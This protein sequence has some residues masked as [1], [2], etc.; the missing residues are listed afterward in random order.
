[1]PYSGPNDPNLPD[2]VKK[3][4]ADLQRS[5]IRTYE[6]AKQFAT[7]K[8]LANV[9]GYAM[10]T[11]NT[12]L[13]KAKAE[14]SERNAERMLEADAVPETIEI[15]VFRAGDYGEKGVYSKADVRAMAEDYCADY[16]EAPVTLDHVDKGQAFGWVKS[17]R[18]QGETLFATLHEFAPEF[19]DLLQA[20]KFR[21]RSAEIYRNFQ[22]TGRPHLRAVTFLG[23]GIPAVKG[24]RDFSFEEADAQHGDH[25]VIEYEI[26]DLGEIELTK[27]AEMKTEDGRQFPAKAYAYVPD[28]QKPSTWKL[29]L[30]ETPEKKV[31]AAQLGRAAAAFSPGG[32]RGQKVQIPAGDIARIKARIRAAYR[33]LGV[34][35]KAIPA[36]IRASETGRFQHCEFAMLEEAEFENTK[37]ELTF[38]FLKPGFNSAPKGSRFSRYYSEE[39]I[40]ANHE[41]FRGKMFADHK[42]DETSSPSVR[43]IRSW[44]ANCIDTW[45]ND[46]GEAWGRAKIVE[47]WFLEKLK[48]L[49]AAELLQEM[50]TSIRCLG[51]GVRTVIEGHDTLLVESITSRAAQTAIDFVTHGRAGGQV[52]MLEAAAEIYESV[53]IPETDIDLATE[54]TLRDRRPEL[55]ELIESKAVREIKTEAGRMEKTVEELSAELEQKTA[56]VEKVTAE[57]DLTRKA[58]ATAEIQKKVDAALAE[59]QLPD[60]AK[61]RLRQEFSTRD[62]VE[63]I[64]EAIAEAVKREEQY[65]AAVRGDAKVRGMGSAAPGDGTQKLYEQRKKELL[66]EGVPEAEA[67][68]RAR[69]YA[70]MR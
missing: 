11:A 26:G 15:E 67:D 64:D 38:R 66:G 56:E 9:E 48:K 40:E 5:W 17:L 36:S 25:A 22:A 23:A 6:S 50:G 60:P 45:T 2:H 44:V 32:H 55:V 12:A 34:E 54:K 28:R 59:T 69:D 7:K 49:A 68:E 70:Q 31:T 37:D 33:S 47:A 4:S 41:R 20:R 16:H 21:K 24:M 29:R 58:A 65:V 62:S 27:A 61:E 3:E 51:D 19:T 53:E 8:R 63:G 1:M 30:W 10:R 18:A 13:K 42:D 39:F 57:L 14:Q 46:A 35:P 43:S 52:E